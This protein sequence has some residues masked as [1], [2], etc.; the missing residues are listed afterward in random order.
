MY[1]LST[2][3]LSALVVT[4]AYCALFKPQIK[5]SYKMEKIATIL[6]TEVQSYLSD[7]RDWMQLMNTSKSLFD[8]CKYETIQV[9]VPAMKSCYRDN[10]PKS[11][12]DSLV[13]K[14]KFT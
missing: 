4:C 5:I 14:I 2:I 13:L 9:T 6:W 10:C 7:A 11:S 12:T 1:Y 8:H 3:Y